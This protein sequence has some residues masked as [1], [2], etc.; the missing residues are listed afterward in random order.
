MKVLLRLHRHYWDGMNLCML[1]TQFREIRHQEFVSGMWKEEIRCFY[2]Y[3]FPASLQPLPISVAHV[4]HPGCHSLVL[5]HPLGLLSLW[6]SVE[7]LCSQGE[8]DTLR[9]YYAW[10]SA[11]LCCSQWRWKLRQCSGSVQVLCEAVCWG[12][13]L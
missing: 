10:Q 6:P 9:V 4:I 12:S 3:H 2:G 13:A 8:L 1:E 11:C 5:C 7:G